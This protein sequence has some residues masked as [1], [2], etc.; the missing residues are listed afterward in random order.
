MK[1]TCSTLLLAFVGW[2]LLTTSAL[3]QNK[4]LFNQ[5]PEFLPVDQ[6]FKIQVIKEQPLTVGIEIQPGYYL[7][8]HAFKLTP[9][10]VLTRPIDYPPAESH[11]DE[12]FGES[13]VY[14]NYVELTYPLNNAVNEV[15]FHYQGCADA[16][17]CYPPETRVISFERNND[18][19]SNASPSA[20]TAN[21]QIQHVDIA[22]L[23]L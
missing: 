4:N 15:T 9:E 12:F 23:G 18:A 1:K 13:R 7:Y 16:G 11:I 17:L 21:W 6:A 5:Q 22:T 10:S 3:A 8:Q 20:A 2:C 19:P 14:R